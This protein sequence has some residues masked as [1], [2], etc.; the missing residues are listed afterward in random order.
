M[1]GLKEIMPARLVSEKDKML[2]RF[3]LDMA[4]RCQAE[5]NAAFDK[6]NMD[7]V[8][9]K[10]H[11]SYVCHAIVSCYQGDHNGC[12]KYSLVCSNRNSLKTWTEKSAYLKNNFKLNK[13]ENTAALLRECVKYRLGPTML[14][15]TCKNTNTQKAEATNRAIRATVPSNVTFTRNYKGRVHTAIHNVNNG[16]GE[17]IVKLCQAAGVPIEPG[18]RAAHGL[19]NIQQHNEKH[20]LYKQ[21]KQYTDQRC[22]KKHELYK[23]YDEYQEEKDYEKNKLLPTKRLAAKQPQE[24]S[25]AKKTPIKT[26]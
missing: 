21:S 12:T 14:N 8:R 26:C 23:I 4:A 5:Y 11:L 22:S 3:A 10:V 24:Y 15:R 9:V 1:S 19:K 17:S 16:P 20:K 13:S 2:K 18:S 7:S 6:F 25:F